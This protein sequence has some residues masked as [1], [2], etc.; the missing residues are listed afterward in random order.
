[1][2]KDCWIVKHQHNRKDIPAYI[3]GHAQKK[4]VQ[5]GSYR[6]AE[7]DPERWIKSMKALKEGRTRKLIH[8]KVMNIKQNGQVR[9]RPVRF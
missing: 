6:S 8:Q 1:M 7:S 3:S 4:L 2:W 9:K 5:N